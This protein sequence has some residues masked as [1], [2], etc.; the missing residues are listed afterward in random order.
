MF[1]DFIDIENYGFLIQEEKMSPWQIK[2]FKDIT[3][4]EKYILGCTP[5]LI[6]ENVGLPLPQMVSL[7]KDRINPPS[8]LSHGIDNHPRTAV[9]VKDNKLYF[10]LVDGNMDL[11]SYHI[12]TTKSTSIL[13]SILQRIHLFRQIDSNIRKSLVNPKQ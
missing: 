1:E 4:K 2:K 5:L 8:V 3:L 9:G 6:Y 7:E 12:F 11:L 10:L 13:D